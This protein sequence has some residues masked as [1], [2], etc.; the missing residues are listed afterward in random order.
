MKSWMHSRKKA[1]QFKKTILLNFL[2]LKNKENSLCHLNHDLK[3]FL[4]IQFGLD[5]IRLD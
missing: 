2:S 1:Q 4:T 5:C 3:T